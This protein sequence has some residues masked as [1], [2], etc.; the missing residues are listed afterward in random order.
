MYSHLAQIKYILPE[1]VQI[2][3]ILVHDV[4]TLCIKPD[5]K[6]SLL[7]DAIEGHQEQFALRALRQVF[8]HRLL[9]F[10]NT[11]TKVIALTI[12]SLLSV[13]E[14][15]VLIIASTPCIIV[16]MIINFQKS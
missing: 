3:Y 7:F 10:F 15:V 14:L 6:I 11:H 9:D 16:I 4:K 1:V 2:D 13:L 12:L 8:A 5:M